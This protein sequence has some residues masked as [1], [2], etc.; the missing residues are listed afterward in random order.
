MK[1]TGTGLQG[2]FVAK[3]ARASSLSQRWADKTAPVW[4]TV[5]MKAPSNEPTHAPQADRWS[6]EVRSRVGESGWQATISIQGGGAKGAWEAG[7]L[8]GL[9]GGDSDIGINAIWGTS[10]GAINAYWASTTP[11]ETLGSQLLRCWTRVAYRA[12]L[13]L[14]LGLASFITTLLLCWPAILITLLAVGIWFGVSRVREGR[15]PGLLPVRFTA[16]FLPRPRVRCEP[17]IRTYFCAADV[18]LSDCPE[19]WSFY[20]LGIFQVQPGSHEAEQI[21]PTASPP[22]PARIAAM[23][24]AAVPLFSKSLRVGQ[25]LF[26]D[27]G[28]EA[29]LPAGHLTSLGADGGTCAVIIIPQPISAL[30]SDNHISYRTLRFLTDFSSFVKRAQDAGAR[31]SVY[32]S[33]AF[34]PVI[35]VSP[36]KQLKSGSACGFLWPRWL[37][38][39]HQDGLKQGSE[40]RQALAAFAQGDDDAL[41]PYLLQ[42]Q[43][44]PELRPLP[45]PGWFLSLWT[46]PEWRR[47]RTQAD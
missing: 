19:T 30:S 40:L 25:H 32:A 42:C 33:I 21:M 14:V 28:L 8:G 7:V 37:R 26:L 46:N 39:D 34:Q 31:T 36:P 3:Q 5:P 17:H 15:L 18:S 11:R 22:I 9:L 10:A 23:T 12:L 6:R 27:G 47:Q 20:T 45:R 44:L 24:S 35:L 16:Q 41:A 13:V 29:N 4:Y 43:E 1:L 38:Q 2:S